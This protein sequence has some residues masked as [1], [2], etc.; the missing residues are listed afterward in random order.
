MNKLENK[1]NKL[2]IKT[3]FYVINLMTTTGIVVFLIIK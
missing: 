2:F 3:F 1:K